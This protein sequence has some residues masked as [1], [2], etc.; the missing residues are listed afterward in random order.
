MLALAGGGLAAYAHLNGNLKTVQLRSGGGDTRALAAAL[1]L[2]ILV[3]GSDSRATAADCRIGGD[4]NVH[5]STSASQVAGSGNADV[6]MLVHLAADR[7]TA[8]VVSIPRDTIV[9]LPPCT[10]PVTGHVSPARRDRINSSLAD[11][12]DCT[13]AAVHRLTGLKIDHFVEIDFAG[14]ITMSNAIGGVQICVNNN[15]YDP[16]SHLKL[17]AGT[18]TLQGLSA[19]EFLRTRHGFGDGSD[20]GRTEAQHLFLA[21]M[22]KHIDSAAT[23]LNPVALYR[24]ADAATKAITV[25]QGLGSV[26]EL[27]TLAQQLN[28]IPAAHIDFVT[29]PTIPNPQNWATVLPAPGA[30][31]LFQRIAEGQ[32]APASGGPSSPTATSGGAA[33]AASTARRK[34]TTRHTTVPE[35]AQVS[36]FRT[37]TVNGASVTPTQAY[38][39]SPTVPNSAP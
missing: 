22:L 38:A 24:L 20:I 28:N 13:V 27:V 23:L 33:S 26:A 15:V 36:R 14:V 2:N 39:L 21:A 6:E 4:C 31:E 11:G 35:C 29:M 12:P 9:D 34:P 7:K 25:D 19:L 30:R 32:P 3:L 1:P 10:N 18:H 37:V 5:N 8:S 17:S 16:Y